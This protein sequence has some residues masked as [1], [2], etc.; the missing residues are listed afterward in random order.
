M[1]GSG[2]CGGVGGVGI[3]VCERV[4]WD[5]GWSGVGWFPM[6][7]LGG[8]AVGVASVSTLGCKAGVSPG[9]GSG[10]GTGGVGRGASTLGVTGGFSLG[11]GWF[12]CGG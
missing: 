12:W 2:V 1:G 4:R 5:N 8:I 11:A 7:I 9:D 3:I 10:G 6:D